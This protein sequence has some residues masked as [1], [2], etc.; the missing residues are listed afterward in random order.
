MLHIIEQYK[1]LFMSFVI[2]SL[3]QNPSSDLIIK[4][5][6]VKPIDSKNPEVLA[7]IEKYQSASTDVVKQTKDEKQPLLS[8]TKK[9]INFMN[10]LDKLETVELA[11]VLTGFSEP[12]NSKSK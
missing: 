12:V 11:N 4:D 7:A 9:S 2:N 6:D 1:Q 8:E 10:R 5:V 3:E